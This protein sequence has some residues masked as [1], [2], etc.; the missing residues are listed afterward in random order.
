MHNP[1]SLTPVESLLGAWLLRA[2]GQGGI[3]LFHIPSSFLLVLLRPSSFQGTF[4][5]DA[6]T[7]PIFIISASRVFVTL[8]S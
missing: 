8:P 1:I 4:S 6:K 3:L 2:S 5:S 7:A